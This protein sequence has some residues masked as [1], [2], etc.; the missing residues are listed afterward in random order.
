MTK[1]LYVGNLGYDVT[2]E[3]LRELFAQFGSVQ[4]VTIITDRFTGRSKGFAFVEMEGASEA[5][6]AISNLNGTDLNGRPLKV[7][8]ARPQAPRAGGR[9]GD[10]GRGGER[11]RGGDR[12]GGRGRGP[13]RNDW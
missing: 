8:E 6:T 7:D 1:K 10:R 5:Q 11:G 4:S 2:E 13:R 3:Q 12:G 9:E